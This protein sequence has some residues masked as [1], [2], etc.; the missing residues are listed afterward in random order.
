M[1]VTLNVWKSL[2]ANKPSIILLP[3]HE[4]RIITSL[5]TMF[6][7][8]LPIGY[9]LAQ[10]IIHRNQA[11]IVAPTIV[12]T[13]QRRISSIETHMPSTTHRFS[14]TF[15]PFKGHLPQFPLERHVSPLIP[16]PNRL[17]KGSLLELPTT[18]KEHVRSEHLR[19]P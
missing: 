18:N 3:Y 11:G 10:R 12:R 5:L 2:N 19:Q 6:A 13:Q 8:F 1:Q 7:R 16:L 17:F 14:Q 4:G 15:Q 9:Q